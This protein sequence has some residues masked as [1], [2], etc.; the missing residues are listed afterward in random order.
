MVTRVIDWVRAHPLGDGRIIPICV[1]GE[2]GVGK[3][4][5]IRS[6][7]RQRKLS[8]RG[9]HPAHDT[10]GADI[11]GLPYIDDATQRTVY[12]RPRWLPTEND[13]TATSK[14]GI[15]FIDEINRAPR[16]VLAGLMEPLGEG[17]IEHSS[18]ILPDGWGFICAANPPN[19]SYQVHELDPAMMNRML[20]IAL[21]FDAVKWGS[22]AQKAEIDTEMI[23]FLTR[24]PEMMAE[25][26]QDLPEGLLVQATPRSFE[27][28]SRLYEPGMDRELLYV[29]ARG[30]IGEDM[31]RLLI[32]HLQGSD[33]P[34]RPEEVFRGQFQEKLGA[35]I[36][37]GRDDLVRSSESLLL[38]MMSRYKP[39]SPEDCR[40]IVTYIQ[41]LGAERGQGFINGIWDQAPQWMDH[42]QHAFGRNLPP[43]R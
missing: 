16:E 21:G 25:A 38:A 29:F 11:V 19:S 27:Y 20:H 8:F 28:L 4:V 12:A 37:S 30:L 7:C 6:F 33:D 3:T 14:T 10:S 17:T 22:W 15:I 40:H 9:Y 18:W 26:K 31:A 43:V 5:F 35:H 2:R 32:A 23:S 13:P 1:W 34:V 36:T 41:M 39:D 42:L 24:Y